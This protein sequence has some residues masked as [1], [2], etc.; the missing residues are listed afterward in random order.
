MAKGLRGAAAAFAFAVLALTAP[1]A[2]AAECRVLVHGALKAGDLQGATV[3]GI[4]L[5]EIRFVGQLRVVPFTYEEGSTAERRFVDRCLGL[6]PEAFRVHWVRLVFR[7]GV[8]P[9]R[10]VGSAVAMPAAVAATAG[11]VG[12]L[13][14]DGAAV[15]DLPSQVWLLTY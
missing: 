12:Y 5:G 8:P 7:E 6:T 15:P 4:F 14:V 9:P 13:P 2:G 1:M 10:Q 3:K 11:G